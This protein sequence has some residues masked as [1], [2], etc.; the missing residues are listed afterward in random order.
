MVGGEVTTNSIF[1]ADTCWKISSGTFTCNK[2]S[3]AFLASFAN[4]RKIIMVMEALNNHFVNEKGMTLL[5]PN[6][7]PN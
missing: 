7:F 3:T 2:P 5:S 4:T 6:T 1:S